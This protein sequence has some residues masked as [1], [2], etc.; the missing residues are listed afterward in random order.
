MAASAKILDRLLRSVRAS[1]KQE[2]AAQWQLCQAI[3]RIHGE[4]LW[5]MRMRAD[6]RPAYAT[7]KQFC[8]AELGISHY[9]SYGMIGVARSFSHA[10]LAKHGITKLV[11]AA[12]VPE[13]DRSRLLHLIECGANVRCLRDEVAAVN[14]MAKDSNSEIVVPITQAADELRV[15]LYK[16]CTRAAKHRG[17]ARLLS[18][19]QAAMAPEQARKAS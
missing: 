7:W 12:R 9:H 11:L 8:D 14:R 19:V 6:G 16:W 2:A 18:R 10:L 13:G 15:E 4:D 5:K 3:A 17:L 1:K